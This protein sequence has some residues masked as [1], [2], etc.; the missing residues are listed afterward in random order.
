MPWMPFPPDPGTDA[1]ANAN[2][3]AIRR[4]IAWF[5]SVLDARFAAHAAGGE[6]PVALPPPPVLPD[7]NGAYARILDQLQPDA[8]ERLLLILALLPEYA[9]EMLDPF[10]IHNQPLA[11]RFTEFGGLAGQSHSGFLP[12]LQTA[13]FVL[14]GGDHGRRIACRRLFEPDHRFLRRGVLIL[15]HRSPDEPVLSAVLR[16]SREYLDRMIS[17]H[18]RDPPP[19]SDFPARRMITRLEWADLVLDEPTLRQVE[20]IGRWLR[21]GGTLMRAWKLDRRLKPGYR[22]L[23]YGPPG[24]GKTLTACLLGKAAGL[25]VY[26]VDLSQVVSK[27]IGETEKNLAGLF[28]QAQFRDWIL[29]FDEAESL[30]GRRG[31]SHSANDRAANQ[32]IAYLLQRVEDYP[33]LVIL[34]TNQ[35]ILMDDAFA[36]RFQSAIHFPMP[37]AD[38]RHRLWRETFEDQAARLT[39]EIDFRRLADEHELSGGA[40]LNVARYVCL[41]AAD[42][43]P[44]RILLRDLLEA[45]RHEKHKDNRFL[46]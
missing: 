9:P 18:D 5:Q 13:L 30:F 25:P 31:E 46:V 23:F 12:T 41:L 16:L 27:W 39:P 24:T 35:R 26:R 7:R 45:I 2:A 8:D 15:D 37:D 40:I 14:A 36:R 20:M 19:G 11:R 28:D 3:N 21:H 33:G 17:G 6:E 22:C 44:P 29:F 42:R 32:Q 38:G 43:D 34:A 10:L 4:D 1:N